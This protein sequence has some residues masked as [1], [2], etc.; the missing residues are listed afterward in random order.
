MARYM[1]ESPHKPEECLRALDEGL[2]KGKEILDKF[3]FGC[4][5]GDHTGYAL[6]DANT[7]KE[8][9]NKYVPDFIREKARIIEVG[10]F[11][12]EMIKSFHSKA[13]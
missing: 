10:K 6:V 1:I 8:A 4:K 13:A 5:A 3:E 2:A 11:T 7:G 12:P 9:L